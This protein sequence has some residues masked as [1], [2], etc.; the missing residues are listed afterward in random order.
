[1]TTETTTETTAPDPAPDPATDPRILELLGELP[2]SLFPDSFIR[3][4]VLVEHYGDEWRLELARRLDLATALGAVEGGDGEQAP[5]GA[6]AG[7]IAARQGFVPA[8]VPALEGLLAGLAG[9]GHLTTTEATRPRRYRLAGT[10]RPARLAAVR[11]RLLDCEPANAPTLDLLDRAGEASVGVA[12]GEV[13]G[14]EVLLGPAGTAL[15]ARYFTNDNPLYGINNRV[16]AL[17]AANRLPERGPLTLLEVGAGFG[18]GSQALL[19]E[20]ATRGGLERIARYHITEPAPFFRRRAQRS[21][22]AAWPGVALVFGE[23]DIDRPW[24]EQGHEPGSADLVFGVNVVHVARN[25][26]ATLHQAFE[27]LRPG[28]WLVAG[29]CLRPFPDQALSAELIFQLLEGF[30]GVETDPELRPNAGF[31]TPEQW[32]RALTHAG[33]TGVGTVPD[34][35]PIRPLSRYFLTGAVCGQRPLR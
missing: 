4:A 11:Q 12:R 7:E 34:M 25:L 24:A 8:F 31:L 16:A 35:G 30:T 3:G 19:E 23:L 6:T 5:G 22:A 17:A 2:A 33:F 28:G 29:E 20:L 14:E 1:M 13:R 18:S 21:L 10:L 9:A 32:C 27:A 15:W 26:A